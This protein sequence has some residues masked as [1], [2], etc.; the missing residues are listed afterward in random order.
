[1]SNFL[2]LAT[3][4]AALQRLLQ[5]AAVAAVPGAV[6]TT[7]RP[8][9][10]TSVTAASVNIYLFQAV[11]DPSSRNR[12]LPTRRPDG[13][14]ASR[15]QAALDLHYLITFH[16]KDSDLE[17]QRL[18]GSTIRTLHARPVITRDLI[19]AVVTAAVDT[20][21]T[22]AALATTDLGDA[23][24]VVRLA[25][26]PLDL[27]QLSKLWSVFFQTPYA[28]SSAWS[29][30]VVMVEES[31]PVTPALPVARS[32]LSVSTLARPTI[33][34][35]EPATDPSLPI[36]A[37]ITIRIVGTALA[38]PETSIHIG[39]AVLVPT[40]VSAVSLLADLSTVPVSA[41]RAG[42]T[43]VQVV[44]PLFV[45]SPPA[46]RGEIASNPLVILVHP[47]VTAATVAG[48]AA[49]IT[50][51]VPVR[52]GQAVALELL[53]PATGATVRLYRAPDL[54]VPTSNVVVPMPGLA[55][56]VYAAVVLVD[57]AASAVQRDAAGVITAPLVSV[58]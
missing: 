3:V 47:R 20:P 40:E 53:D 41:L 58:P 24:D 19:D 21:P 18:M 9:L 36:T 49:N 54:T 45:G 50:L 7:D 1:M 32:V 44:H 46:P 15:P 31:D 26:M 12:D 37:G 13:T 52:V 25:P 51:D 39:D 43:V 2:A 33:N 56:G 11:P 48:G 17:Q 4:T 55:T 30:S 5:P 27:E 22:H 28:L 29:A 8:D 42:T 6:V 57:G 35:V 14:M 16:G 23:V 38:G 10:K 34:R